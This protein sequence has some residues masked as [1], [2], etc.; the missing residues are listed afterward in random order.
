MIISFICL[1]ICSYWFYSG[2]PGTPESLIG[3]Y[4]L[5]G[6]TVGAVATVPIAAVRAFPAA[7][8]FS[9]LSFSYNVSYAVFGGLTPIMLTLWMQKDVMAPAHYV[10]S[11]AIL[12][13]VLAFVPLTTSLAH[14]HFGEAKAAT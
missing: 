9:G 3:S 14:W 8:R 12:G 11:L 10:S 2:L 6:F 1:M 4:V 7:I 5:T 13:L